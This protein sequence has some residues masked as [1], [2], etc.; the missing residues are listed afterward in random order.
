M[1]LKEL[2]QITVLGLGLL[3]ASVTLAVSRTLSA[4]KTV[5]FSHRASTRAKARKLGVA[6]EI[7]DDIAAAVADGRHC[8]FGYADMHF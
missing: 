5:G 2:R 3:G 1:I 7:A 8:Y 4:V 6:Q